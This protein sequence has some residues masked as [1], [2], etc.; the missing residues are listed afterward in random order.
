[1]MGVTFD[2]R[3]KESTLD[4]N[5]Y[6]TPDQIESDLA[7][8][9]GKVHAIRIYSMLHGQD[10][11]AELAAKHKLNITL[12]AWIGDEEKGDDESKLHQREKNREEI[13]TL[14]Q[15]SRQNNPKIVRLLV[16]NETLLRGDVSPDKLIEYLREVRKRTWRPVSTSETWDQWMKH[17]ELVPEVDYLAVHFLPYWEG[18]NVDDAVDHVFDRYHELQA[19]YPNKPIVTEVGWPSNGQPNKHATASLSNQ[20]K[21]LREFL[22]RA[23]EENLTYYV[24]EAFDQP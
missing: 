12:G 7:L 14:I 9:S 16:G 17:P 6:P 23:T 24:V 3:H 22:N 4:N 2:P 5:N 13:E 8:L 21:F 20:A 11:I 18:I 10:I 19:K 1:M 15:I